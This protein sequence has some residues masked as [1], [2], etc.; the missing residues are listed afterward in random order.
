MT[1]LL[2]IVFLSI[3]V[4]AAKGQY[5]N[6]RVRIDSS[7]R[8]YI[9]QVTDDNRR[10]NQ[11]LFYYWFKSGRIHKTQGG[12]YGKLLH[13][14][15]KVVDRD[16]HLLEEGQFKKGQKTG[17]WRSWYTDGVLQST[18]RKRFGFW[19]NSY[20]IKEYDANGNTIKS[21]FENKDLFTGYQVN[22]QGDSSV[23]TRYKKA[24]HCLTHN[25]RHVLEKNYRR[26]LCYL[27]YSFR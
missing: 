27:P 2:L 13:G 16:R 25:Y 7:D 24:R 1:R 26:P 23:V 22:L 20:A 9:F 15:Y 6:G 19:N 12:Y 8:S 5:Y 3:V 18:R 10:T 11:G 21:G 4:T 14:N 17:L